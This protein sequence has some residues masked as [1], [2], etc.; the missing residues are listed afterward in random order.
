MMYRSFLAVLFP[1]MI[2]ILAVAFSLPGVGGH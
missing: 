2:V 1:L